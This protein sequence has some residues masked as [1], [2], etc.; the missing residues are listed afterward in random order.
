M[1]LT[2][3]KPDPLFKA[4]RDAELICVMEKEFF[5]NRATDTHYLE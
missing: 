3:Q 4:I 2:F 1:I 5:F